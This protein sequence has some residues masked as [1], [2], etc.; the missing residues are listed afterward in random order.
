M[1]SR[2]RLTLPPVT[3]DEPDPLASR[4]LEEPAKRLGFVIEKVN[5]NSMTRPS[6]PSRMMREST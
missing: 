4:N 2:Y 1:L 3:A 6:F 5:S